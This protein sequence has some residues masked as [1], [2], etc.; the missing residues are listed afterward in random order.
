MNTMRKEALDFDDDK[1]PASVLMAVSVIVR[2]Y[3]AEGCTME[4]IAGTIQRNLPQWKPTSASPCVTTLVA[5]GCARVE[6]RFGVRRVYHVRDYD[7][8]DDGERLKK[9]QAEARERA[10]LKKLGLRDREVLH[11]TASSPKPAPA[12]KPGPTRLLIAIGENRT[13]TMT[14]E[15]ARAL[16]EQLRAIFEGVR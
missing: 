16:Y 15:E 4:D 8:D 9:M 14:V 11:V 5:L 7:V 13:E 10:A 3:G 1:K 2:H 6:H 12:P